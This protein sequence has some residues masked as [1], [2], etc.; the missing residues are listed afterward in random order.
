LEDLSIVGEGDRGVELLD[1]DD[2]SL[3][4]S[5]FYQDSRGINWPVSW[6]LNMADEQFTINALLDQ[7]TVDLSILYW[8][9]LVEVLNPDGSRS[10]LGYMELT[11][12]ER[13]R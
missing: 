4:P 2:F 12:Y 1:R 5:R 10:G 6:T 3:K 7:Q 11:G 13:N 8:E 9:G